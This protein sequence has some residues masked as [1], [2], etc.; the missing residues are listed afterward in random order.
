MFDLT[1]IDKRLHEAEVGIDSVLVSVYHR[2]YLKRTH[3]S[4]RTKKK[5]QNKP[6]RVNW[7][8]QPVRPK[9]KW[10]VYCHPDRK[11]HA[12]GLC[13]QCY[14]TVLRRMKGIQEKKPARVAECHPERK[15]YVKGQCYQCWN[16]DRMRRYRHEK[17]A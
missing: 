16:R 8:T 1:D 17:A 5:S 2:D 10:I 4:I 6:G 14:R 12:V 9:K 3:C 13:K 7:K 11:Y 15:H